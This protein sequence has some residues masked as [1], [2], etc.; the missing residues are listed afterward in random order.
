MTTGLLEM[1]NRVE[2]EGVIA[3]EL[4][5]VKN[6]DILVTTV[7]V[8]A[9]GAIA[10]IADIGLRFVFW[11]GLQRPARQQR[12]RRRSARSS[13]SLALALLVLAPFAALR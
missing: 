12:L 7:A 13:R 1:M 10:L 9:V 2:L 3:H 6:Y 8:T 11:G 5:H 4:A